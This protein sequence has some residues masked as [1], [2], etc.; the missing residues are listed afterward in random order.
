MWTTRQR[1]TAQTHTK[2]LFGCWL[3][4]CPH[5]WG[6][7]R[8]PRVEKH[9]LHHDPFNPITPHLEPAHTP[10]KESRTKPVFYFSHTY[11]FSFFS[12]P[13]SPRGLVKTSPR[14]E[15]KVEPIVCNSCGDKNPSRGLFLLDTVNLQVGLWRKKGK[16]VK[17]R[18]V[19][20]S[21]ELRLYLSLSSSFWW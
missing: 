14:P 19:A 16:M 17:R 3:Q 15:T 5:L 7:I 2:A 10:H 18:D 20:R 12:S 4:T 21:G 1:I 6:F 9:L 11:I 13:V 8:V